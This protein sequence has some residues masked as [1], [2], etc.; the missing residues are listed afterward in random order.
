MMGFDSKILIVDD[1]KTALK[2]MERR[3]KNLG[4]SQVQTIGSPKKALAMM[5]ENDYDIVFLDWI[6]PEMEGIEL[7]KLMK[8]A[9]EISETVKVIMLT[10]ENVK[11]K[12][13]SAI[14]LGVNGYI[15]KPPTNEKIMNQLDRL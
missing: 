1:S 7:F 3:L 6:M 15:L 13:I 5:K 12:V 2:V 4:F 10:A 9:P 11:D 14:Q 8:A